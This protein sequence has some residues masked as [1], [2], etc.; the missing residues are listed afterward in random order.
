MSISDH[1]YNWG[2]DYNDYTEFMFKVPIVH[3]SARQCNLKKNILLN[4][5][6]QSQIEYSANEN[7]KSDYHTQQNGDNPGKYN[8]QIDHLFKEEINLFCNKF[9]FS[10]YRIVMSWFEKATQG[11]YHGIHNHGF[12]GYSAVC[13]IDYDKEEHTPTQFISPFNNFLTGLTLHY[14]PQVEEG[15]II[16]FPSTILHHTEPN[17][18]TKERKILSFNINVI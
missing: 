15:S 4:I 3:I 14:S 2:S 5:M 7:I 16:F 10:Q 8:E 9:G 11:N 13:F 6:N 18:S 17:K 1:Q 12:V